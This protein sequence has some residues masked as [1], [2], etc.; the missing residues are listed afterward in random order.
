MLCIIKMILRL[1][2][3]EQKKLQKVYLL[4][5]T[6]RLIMESV[7]NVCYRTDFNGG[8]SSSLRS[9]EILI[10]LRNAPEML[11]CPLV[12][13]LIHATVSGLWLA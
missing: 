4:Y 13:Y 8:S 1:D 11:D 5:D 6:L 2:D 9:Y 3:L 7:T 12:R 10:I